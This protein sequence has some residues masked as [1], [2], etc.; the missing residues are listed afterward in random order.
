VKYLRINLTQKVKRPV[1]T[2]KYKIVMK[3][4]ED[5]TNKWKDI[6][7][8]WI[9]KINI[10]KMSIIPPKTDSMQSLSKFQWQFAKKRKKIPKF[11]WNNKRP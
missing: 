6:P 11:I 9:G 3:E 5:D 2:E 8:L 4:I 10:V 1:H 7:Y